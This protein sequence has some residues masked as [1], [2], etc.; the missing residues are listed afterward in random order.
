M[1][2]G[3]RVRVGDGEPSIAMTRFLRGVRERY[4]QLSDLERRAVARSKHVAIQMQEEAQDL[5]ERSKE[6]AD[7]AE[8]VD[9]KVEKLKLL[10][11]AKS[12]ADQARSLSAKASSVAPKRSLR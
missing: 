12:D 7:E 10:V 1:S 2:K 9:D 5:L 6:L 11:Q 4:A 8:R 3:L